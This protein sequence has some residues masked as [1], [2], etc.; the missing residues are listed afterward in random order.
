M[1]NKILESQ[2]HVLEQL[3][4]PTLPQSYDFRLRPH[5]R[6]IPN[7]C[8]HLTD[9]NF[10]IRM[11]FADTYWWC[12]FYLSLC[13]YCVFLTLTF[14]ISVGLFLNCSLSIFSINKYCITRTR[15]SDATLN[16]ETKLSWLFPNFCHSFPL[17]PKS[18]FSSIF[19]FL[20]F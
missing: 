14:N 2:Y 3:L 5:T 13:L 12:L 7:R 18:F 10:L 4:P 1:F 19:G 8:S 20:T 16:D 17:F 15:K 6:Q 9:C 11:L